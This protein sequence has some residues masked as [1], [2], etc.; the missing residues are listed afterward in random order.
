LGLAVLRVE[1]YKGKHGSP[2]RPR[3]I[4]KRRFDLPIRAPSTVLGTHAES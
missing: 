4:R 3:S 1:E 2:V